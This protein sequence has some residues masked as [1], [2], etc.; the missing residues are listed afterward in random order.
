[1]RYEKNL[2]FEKAILNKLIQ[3]PHDFISA[4]K[5]LPKNLLIMFI[6][7]YESFLFNKILSERI[8]RKIP[9]HQAIVGDIIFPVRKN[10]I[11]NE[12]I[13]VKESNIAKVNI[14]ITKK[15]AVVTGLLVGYD[16]VFADGEMGEIEHSV[17]D[18]QKINLG[19]FI[20]PE[21]PFLSSSGSRRSLLALMPFLEWALDNDELSQDHQTL[22]L[23]FELPKGCYATSLL[24]EIMKSNNSRNY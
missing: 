9:I 5:E 24:R 14:Q 22:S 13:P 18:S 11:I 1:M 19:D 17:I 2:N 8:R 23:H 3:N 6:N 20:I 7:A 21:I 10:L 15:K 12:F 4:I 16:T